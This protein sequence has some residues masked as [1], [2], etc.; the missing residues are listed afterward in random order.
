MGRTSMLALERGMGDVVDDSI[1]AAYRASFGRVLARL[2]RLTGDLGMAEEVT[3][4]AFASALTAWR[5]AGVPEEPLAWLFRASKNLAIDRLRR[6]KNLAGKIVTYAADLLETA[7]EPSLPTEI[8]DDRLRLVFTCCHPALGL[9]AQVALTLRTLLGLETAEI[10]R[11]FLVPEPTMAQRLVRAKKKITDAK[12]PYEVPEATQMAERL[13]AVLTVLYLVFTEGYTATRGDALLR[14]DLSA[15]AIRLARLVRALTTN[16][17]DEAPGEVTGLL[18]LMLLHDARRAARVDAQGDL[19]VL[20]EQDRSLWDHDAIAE[21]L[22]LVRE[23]M[24]TAPGP[25]AIQAALAA[26]HARARR[27]EDTDWKAILALYDRMT[28]IEDSPIVALNRAVAVAM[29]EGPARGLAL[30]DALA[31]DGSLD[32]YHLLH[33]ARADLARRLGRR[34]EAAASYVRALALAGNASERRYLEK[35]LREVQEP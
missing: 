21:A 19:V 17:N 6:R 2:T 29:A 28:A 30:V 23:A 7:P 20:D 16:E 12:I 3:Q 13:H 33:A 14:T 15:E 22:P 10:A 5:E 31:E 34:K 24:A 26:E 27:K 32:G 11:A 25:F 18:A 4:E 8:P 35:R 9:E 1:S